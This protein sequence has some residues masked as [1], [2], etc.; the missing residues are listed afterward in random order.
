MKLVK[1]KL[2]HSQSQLR[3][4]GRRLFACRMKR[5][6]AVGEEEF[7]MQADAGVRFKQDSEALRQQR[8]KK[9]VGKSPQAPQAMLQLLNYRHLKAKAKRRA[10]PILVDVWL[11]HSSPQGKVPN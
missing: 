9:K 3:T 5:N 6:N 4:G 7:N 10:A 2:S 8:I 11:L 1:T